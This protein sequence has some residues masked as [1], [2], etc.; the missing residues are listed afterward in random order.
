MRAAV[1][2]LVLM[3]AACGS[4]SAPLAQASPSLS[5]NPASA[6]PSATPV[7]TGDLISVA[8]Q[9]YPFQAGRYVTCDWGYGGSKR[10]SHCPV[11]ARLRDRLLTVFSGYISGPEPLGGGQD[12]EWPT[13]SITGEPSG[14]GGVAHVVLTKSASPP[15]RYDLVIV[16]SGGKLLVD[17]IYCTGADPA[18]SSIYGAGWMERVAC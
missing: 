2:A 1:V 13:E 15:N 10:Y 5:A 16:S 6:G 18:S 11:T 17:D 3:L 12:P 9:I 14:A 7:S 4:S 8:E